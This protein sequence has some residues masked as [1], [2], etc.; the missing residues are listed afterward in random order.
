MNQVPT[1]QE[2]MDLR[3]SKTIGMI[4]DELTE[5]HVANIMSPVLT[6]AQCKAIVDQYEA[7][8]FQVSQPIAVFN[9]WMIMVIEP[10]TEDFHNK[11]K[12][13]EEKRNRKA[14]NETEEQWHA[15]VPEHLRVS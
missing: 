10:T 12:L 13:S 7:A 9:C 11:R 1:M 5:K 3:I 6:E 4:N 8:G 14:C 15:R 2:L